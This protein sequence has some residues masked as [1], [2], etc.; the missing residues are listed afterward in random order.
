MEF[1]PLQKQALRS[2]IEIAPAIW[3]HSNILE[4]LD[5][6]DVSHTDIVDTARAARKGRFQS[7]QAM[8][9]DTSI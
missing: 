4:T 8:K 3:E 6:I 9:E 1:K 2:A 7:P 5:R